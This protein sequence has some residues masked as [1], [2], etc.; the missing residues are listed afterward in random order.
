MN[1]FATSQCPTESAQALDNLRVINQ[2]R[3]TGQMVSTALH[4]RGLP[5]PYKAAY[6]SH[7]VTRWVGACEAN[8]LWALDHLVALA[9]EHKHRYPAS[10]WHA[11]FLAHQEI[12]E[13][14]RSLERRPPTAFQNSARN[15]SLA[16][17]FTHI[18]NVHEAYRQY[19]ATRWK[20]AVKP[21]KWGNR[22]APEWLSALRST[23]YHEATPK[24]WPSTV[25]SGWTALRPNLKGF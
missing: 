23:T 15:D 19:I 22:N 6:P 16:L 5:A 11:S 3:E 10:E 12:V 4:A 17:D 13:A 21:P 2:C 25:R 20:L 8:F 24:L 18:T 1:I 9:T 7:P 14:H